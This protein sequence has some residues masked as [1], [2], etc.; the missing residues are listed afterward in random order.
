MTNIKLLYPNSKIILGGDFNLAGI[1]WENCTHI[2]G[3]K[4]KTSSEKLLEMSATY[5]LEQCNL[6]PTRKNNILELCLTSHPGLI[7]KCYTGPGI[8]DHDHIVIV[9]TSLKAKITKKQPRPRQ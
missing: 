7:N 3:T 8:S 9:E 6:L 1:D 5:G 4:E 2:P